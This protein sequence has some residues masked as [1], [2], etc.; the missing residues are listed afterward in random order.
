MFTPDWEKWFNRYPAPKVTAIND[1][2]NYLVSALNQIEGETDVP[3]RVEKV[4]D[5]LEDT[6]TITSNLEDERAELCELSATF[7]TMLEAVAFDPD[8][9]GGNQHGLMAI[10]DW[11][12]DNFRGK[13][14]AFFYCRLFNDKPIPSKRFLIIACVDETDRVLMK[15]R[16][17]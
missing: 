4:F 16:W 9:Y 15:M 2:E 5:L 12:R 10:L 6:L 14:E 1:A 11:A 17:G 7:L 8:N 13:W 3:E